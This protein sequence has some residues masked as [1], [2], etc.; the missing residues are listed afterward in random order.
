MIKEH[1]AK[2]VT[3]GV[4]VMPDGARKHH[5]HSFKYQN[6]TLALDPKRVDWMEWTVGDRRKRR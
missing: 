5:F 2:Y 1:I 3:N 4:K 6:W